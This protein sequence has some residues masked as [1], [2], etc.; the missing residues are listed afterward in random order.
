MKMQYNQIRQQCDMY[1]AAYI[2]LENLGH[3]IPY[4]FPD[5][6]P[7]LLRCL[8]AGVSEDQFKRDAKTMFNV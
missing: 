2:Y 8:D 7:H 6:I 3:H 4:M 1:E 5:L